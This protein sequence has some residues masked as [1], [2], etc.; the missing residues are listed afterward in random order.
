MKKLA[1]A[2]VASTVFTWER[3]QVLVQQ[4]QKALPNKVV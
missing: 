4:Q 2:L 3:I 1:L